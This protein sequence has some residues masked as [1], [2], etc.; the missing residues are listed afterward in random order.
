MTEEVAWRPGVRT[1]LVASAST[2][3]A[4]LCL[5]EQWC[6]PGAGAPPH[7]HPGVEEAIFV[8]AGEAEF[9]LEDAVRIAVTGETVLV[10]AG[11]LHEFTNVGVSTLHTLAVFPDPA[12]PV[13]YEETPGVIYEVGGLGTERLDAHRAIRRA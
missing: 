11:S 8:L 10:P 9:R 1:R 2:G 12:P 13:V 5:F 6:E 7:R 4:Q 3:A